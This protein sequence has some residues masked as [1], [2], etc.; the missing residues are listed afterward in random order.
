MQ[1]KH[2]ATV[3]VNDSTGAF[4]LTTDEAN[5]YAQQGMVCVTVNPD[6]DIVLVDALGASAEV[7]G[8]AANSPWT[9]PAGS[10]TTILHRSGPLRALSV[11]GTAT[12]KRSIGCEP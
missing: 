1:I 8:T 9:C 12:V 2:L 6:V 11:T 5:K 4:I 7:P 3:S 10:P